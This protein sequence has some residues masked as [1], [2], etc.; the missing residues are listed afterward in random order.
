MYRADLLGDGLVL[1]EVKSGA[2]LA[3]AHR[4]QLLNDRRATECEL[5]LLVNFGPKPTF[6]RPSLPMTAGTA[7]TTTDPSV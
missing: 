4:A 3:P 6:E 5:G 1:I 7:A 2:G